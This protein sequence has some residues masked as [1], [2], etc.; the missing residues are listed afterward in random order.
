MA[1]SREEINAEQA[2]IA[3]TQR[4]RPFATIAEVRAAI[5]PW[6]REQ[7][8]V[9]SGRTEPGPIRRSASDRRSA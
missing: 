2:L 3:T 9:G 6:L 8:H 5:R 7:M 1:R 4:D